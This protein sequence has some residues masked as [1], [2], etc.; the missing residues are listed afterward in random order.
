MPLTM[1][2]NVSKKTAIRACSALALGASV[3]AMTGGPAFAVKC[4]NDGKAYGQW[5]EAFSQEAAGQG[6]GKRALSA[7][8]NTKYS[9]ATI[10]ADRNQKSFKLSLEQ[11]MKVRGGNAIISKGKSLKKSNAALFASLEKRYGVPAG[12]LLAI[13]GMETGFGGFMGNENVLSATATL[14][15]DCR[16]SE[17]FTGHLY[18]LLQLIDRGTVSADAKGA[19]HGELGHTQFL[20]GSVLR[21]GVDG[22][23]N[24]SVNMNS[25]ADALA[26][27][28]NFLRGHGW[29]SGAG[30]QPGQS[31]FG[32]IQG[33]NAA[34][35]YQKAIA[36]IAAEIDAG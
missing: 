2:L 1:S 18:A 24:G 34:G 11:F 3:L 20:P 26:S 7:L 22:D 19:K 17:F 14:A 25:K 32:A 29:S 13:W 12:P 36:L 16:R 23:G 8:A 9:K 15:Y 35:V 28:A 27:T 33:W 31:N 4:S 10:S 30:Y 5:V 21:Y 6:I